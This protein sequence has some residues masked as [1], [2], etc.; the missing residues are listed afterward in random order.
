M[1][2]K[3]FKFSKN[4]IQLINHDIGNSYKKVQ[5]DLK[6]GNFKEAKRDTI[7]TSEMIESGY[8]ALERE[9]ADK[10]LYNRLLLN[11][12]ERVIE[13][14]R[15]NGRIKIELGYLGKSYVLSHNEVT[16]IGSLKEQLDKI[17]EQMQER[18]AKKSD[19]KIL[20][21]EEL[22]QLKNYAATLDHVNG[23]QEDIF[24]EAQNLPNLL[25][26]DLQR[27]K[28]LEMRVSGEIRKI[29]KLRL[30]TQTPEIK[31]KVSSFER[32]MVELEQQ[33]KER[34]VNFD[35]INDAFSRAELLINEIVKI[36]DEVE[37]NSK[38]CEHLLQIS[39]RYRGQND[40]FDQ[41]RMQAINYYNE[42]N[43]EASIM[44]ISD[45][46]E[47]IDPTVVANEL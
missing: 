6:Q 3:E 40:I 42:G 11:I 17:N 16:E 18:K 12:S 34:Q 37:S 38:R 36:G 8:A 22:V 9:I 4:T 47:A 44:T 2:G 45:A 20:Y 31:Q 1:N 21:S 33:L 32:T 28:Q 41:S 7:S 46:I 24:K 29:D 14:R 43:Y 23:V 39:N 26:D 25:R 27:T 30:P 13:L 35:K 19:I 15:K 5:S 10:S